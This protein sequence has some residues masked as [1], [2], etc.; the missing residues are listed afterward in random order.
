MGA[1]E[2]NQGLGQMSG[3]RSMG[4]APQSQA[5]GMQPRPQAQQL[6]GV[7]QMMS[8]QGEAVDKLMR[9]Y[10]EAMMLVAK[11][12][13][14]K[15]MKYDP[16]MVARGQDGAQQVLEAF[17]MAQGTTG[18]QRPQ[19]APRQPQVRQLDSSVD[20]ITRS[21][22]GPVTGQGDQS[23]GNQRNFTQA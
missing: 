11:E 14:S 22:A 9:L 7:N 5:G 17:R 23:F 3:Q 4:A 6:P 1:N 21:P 12:F 19:V 2:M 16:Q 8:P 20:P 13:A 10:G 15:G 18:A